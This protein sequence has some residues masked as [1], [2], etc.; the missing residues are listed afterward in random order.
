MTSLDSQPFSPWATMSALITAD[1]FCSPGYLAISRSIFFSDSAD[2]IRARPS[3][4][5]FPENDVL[6]A[7]DGHRVGDHVAA[8]HLV[9]RRQMGET[10]RAQ[11]QAIGLVRA[12]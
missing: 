12:V 4:V 6:R 1:C 10:R 9:E 2:S 5:D 11:L 7:D 8:R 3:P